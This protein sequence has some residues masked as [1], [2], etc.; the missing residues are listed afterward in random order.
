MDSM[1]NC[2]KSLVFCLCIN[3][4]LTQTYF[5]WDKSFYFKLFKFFRAWDEA[6]CDVFLF[7]I[8][9]LEYLPYKI[10]FFA[11][12]IEINMVMSSSGT[13]KS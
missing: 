8:H 10:T 2:R 13:E 5:K 12:K 3:K 7:F 11:Q 4:K 1:K 9:N 6:F